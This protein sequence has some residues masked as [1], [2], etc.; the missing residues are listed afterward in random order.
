MKNQDI[1]AAGLCI[2]VLCFSCKPAKEK[3]KDQITGLEKEISANNKSLADKNKADK[4]IELYKSYSE[5][6]A[7]DTISADYLFKAADL[8][9]GLQEYPQAMVLYKKVCDKYPAY[10]KAPLALFLQGFISENNLHD[11]DQARLLYQDFLNKYPGNPLAKDAKWSIANLG[12]SPQD[13]VKGFESNM[14]EESDTLY[15]K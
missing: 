5:T 13:I 4:V 6:Y 12:K 2:S 15:I 7:D 8:A 11:I 10:P 9:N 3:L 14:V 1:I